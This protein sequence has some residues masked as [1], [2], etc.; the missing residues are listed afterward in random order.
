MILSERHII[1]KTNSLYSELDNLCF[2]SKNIYNSQNFDSI[3]MSNN[4]YNMSSLKMTLDSIDNLDGLLEAYSNNSFRIKRHR[5]FNTDFKLEVVNQTEGNINSDSINKFNTKIVTDKNWGKDEGG[6]MSN[7]M[8]NKPK[9]RNFLL[10]LGKKIVMT[11][12]PRSR[13]FNLEKYDKPVMDDQ[14]DK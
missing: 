12:L 2:L 14:F 9:K 13:K 1:K 8:F 3:K 11:K 5:V 4:K 6:K 10:E 7:V